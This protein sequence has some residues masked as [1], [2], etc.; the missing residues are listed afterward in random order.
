M[1]NV[2]FYSQ[3]PPNILII[4]HY[5]FPQRPLAV[6]DSTHNGEDAFA[7]TRWDAGGVEHLHAVFSDTAVGGIFLRAGYNF[8]N[9]SAQAGSSARRS[10]AAIVSLLAAYA[11]W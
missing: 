4:C 7:S 10:P 8:A 9:T 6:L 2:S 1:L 11:Q 5:D 3:L